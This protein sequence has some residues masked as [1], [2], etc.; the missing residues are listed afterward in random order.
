MMQFN[1]E[2]FLATIRTGH[3]YYF[4]N[5]Q[6]TNTIEPHYHIAMGTITGSEIIF[7]CCTT[8]WGG[9]LAYITRNGLSLSTL[10]YIPPSGTNQ[11]PEKSYVNCNDHFEI[12]VS[13]LKR[14]YEEGKIIIGGDVDEYIF[15]QIK[16]GVKDSDEVEG[17]I[18]EIIKSSNYGVLL[19][20]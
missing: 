1:G 10:V 9:R 2:A 4:K 13:K 18:Q 5:D 7:F 11:L 19:F 15:E 12:G 16:T 17:E 6:L 20:P 3:I 8:K 14:L